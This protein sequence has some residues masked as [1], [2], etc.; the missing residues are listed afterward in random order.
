MLMPEITPIRAGYSNV[1]AATASLMVGSIVSFMEY[2]AGGKLEGNGGDVSV[3]R[4][5]S[6]S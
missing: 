2:L 5:T 1:A 4:C 6:S 3:E